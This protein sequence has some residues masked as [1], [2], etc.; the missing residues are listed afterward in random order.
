VSFLLVANPSSG[1]SGSDQAGRAARELDDVRTP[2]VREG[3]DLAEGV[4][5]GVEE[6]RT[7][8]GA[9]TTRS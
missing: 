3:I 5:R 4:P 8:V 7:V 9:R 2:E 1:S 6:V